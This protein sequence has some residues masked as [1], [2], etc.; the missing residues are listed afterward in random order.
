MS[1]SHPYAI[2][3]APTEIATSDKGSIT[4]TTHNWDGPIPLLETKQTQIASLYDTTKITSTGADWGRLSATVAVTTT[5]TN[6]SPGEETIEIEW[7]ELR[8]PIQS[9]PGFE[10]MTTS[11][12]VLIVNA[13]KEGKPLSQLNL[14]NPGDLC[15]RLYKYLAAGTT[16]YPIGIPV[17]RRTTP[18]ARSLTNGGAYTRDTPPLEISG[19][20]YLKTAD[21]RTKVGTDITRVEEWTGSKEVDPFIY[22]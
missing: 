3:T 18:N 9:H 8:Q 10:D 6:P 19:Y 5:Q 13:A 12:T 14:I 16:E 4:T 11:D 17:I 1:Q 7:V 2:I 21:R 20:Q 22:P 15:D